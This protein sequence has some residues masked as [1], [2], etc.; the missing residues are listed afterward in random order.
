MLL[1]NMS[2]CDVYKVIYDGLGSR[3]PEVVDECVNLL[4]K[5]FYLYNEDS[6]K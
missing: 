5:N 6:F 3:S 4:R 2:L 1:A